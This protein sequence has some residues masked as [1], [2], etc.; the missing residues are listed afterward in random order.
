MGMAVYEIW[1][2]ERTNR[3]DEELHS[4]SH[5][6]SQHDLFWRLFQ[7]STLVV[8]VQ[9]SKAVAGTLLGSGSTAFFH[10]FIFSDL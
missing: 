5:Q 8:I 10:T 6:S 3:E 9:H 2:D 1:H 7:F 4:L